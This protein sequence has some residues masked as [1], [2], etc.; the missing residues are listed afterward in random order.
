M[1]AEKDDIK[2]FLCLYIVFKEEENYFI[3]R[4]ST[5]DYYVLCYYTRLWPQEDFTISDIWYW[6]GVGWRGGNEGTASQ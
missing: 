4:N 5:S 2:G 6:G 1:L 3:E